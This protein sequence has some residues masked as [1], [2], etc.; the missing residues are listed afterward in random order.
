M[1]EKVRIVRKPSGEVAVIHP[2]PKSRREGETEAAWLKRVFE[3]AMQGDL[4][5]RPYSDVLR[6]TLP[7]NRVDRDAWMWDSA[8]KKIKVNQGEA[9][10]ARTAKERKAKI[11]QEALDLAEESLVAKGEL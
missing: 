6:S 1:P 7:P 8:S 5:G 11:A 3:K 2:A 4:K 10:Q 9:D